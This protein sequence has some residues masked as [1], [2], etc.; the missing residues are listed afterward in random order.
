MA[1]MYSKN[2]RHTR[3]R[4]TQSIRLFHIRTTS[5]RLESQRSFADRLL[6]NSALPL[7]GISSARFVP[8]AGLCPLAKTPLCFAVPPLQIEPASLGFDLVLGA[9]SKEN[10]F[11]P[12]ITRRSEI[13]STPFQGGPFRG[14]P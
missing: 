4:N 5:L 3:N 14:P 7:V 8:A 6:Y 2:A 9:V 13:R 1:S 11:Y 12:L 10:R